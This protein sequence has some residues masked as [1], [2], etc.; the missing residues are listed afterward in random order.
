MRTLY[1]KELLEKNGHKL[2]R[3][4][5]CVSGHKYE[6]VFNYSDRQG[7]TIDSFQYYN[8][9]VVDV[10]II[11]EEGRYNVMLIELLKNAEKTAMETKTIITYA[12]NGNDV[13]TVKK[14]LINLA[15]AYNDNSIINLYADISK[16]ECGIVIYKD[17]E[18]CIKIGECY[19]SDTAEQVKRSLQEYSKRVP[20]YEDYKLLTTIS[21]ER[22][23]YIK[24]D[25]I[26]LLRLHNENELLKKALEV[27]KRI[28]QQQE[29]EEEKERAERI[30]K[31][32]QAKAKEQEEWERLW[33][34]KLKFLCGYGDGKSRIQVER[35]YSILSKRGAYS[36]KGK[37]EYL[38]HK[39]FIVKALN[40][41]RKVK[42]C[43]DVVSYY[44]SK[45]NPKESVKTEY[46]LYVE[47]NIYYKLTKTEYDFA[48]YIQSKLNE[49]V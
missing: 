4:N 39:D 1:L 47:D 5:E 33:T 31:E 2:V 49:E 20:T 40:N 29:E 37:Y 6:S 10:G 26:Y 13:I 23:A 11:N 48:L 44:G 42:K 45:W 30:A 19:K 8:D 46:R 41:G 16:P 9:Y 7:G 12:R 17:F 38:T 35:L 3:Y 32:N 27:K 25:C 24:N 15:K 18:P 43:D 28:I 21:I 36:N 34:E 14:S 22:G